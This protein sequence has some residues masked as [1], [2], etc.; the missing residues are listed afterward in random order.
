ME[1]LLFAW[2]RLSKGKHFFLF[3]C[4][5]G[6]FA[7]TLILAWFLRNQVLIK[8]N[9]H[10]KEIWL[11]YDCS[12]SNP[13]DVLQ[14]VFVCVPL[15]SLKTEYHLKNS[16]LYNMG[17]SCKCVP[18]MFYMWLRAIY[19]RLFYTLIVSQLRISLPLA[20]VAN[21][22]GEVRHTLHWSVL[23]VHFT[24]IQDQYFC[25]LRALMQ[26]VLVECVV[27]N[28]F[29]PVC[30]LPPDSSWMG[31]GLWLAPYGMQEKLQ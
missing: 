13:V 14:V 23:T 4:N 18:C 22:C 26:E 6:K 8:K 31:P 21:S 24:H 28:P 10:G 30:F 5:H 15:K 29:L 1:S 25:N 12:K 2:H 7:E 9:L 27:L 16:V 11:Y 17:D 20:L 3:K 19:Q